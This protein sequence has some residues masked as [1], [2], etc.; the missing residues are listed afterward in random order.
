MAKQVRLADGSVETLPSQPLSF[1]VPPYS[2]HADRP[3][4]VTVADVGA[5]LTTQVSGR[6]H[7]LQLIRSSCF[8]HGLLK[9]SCSVA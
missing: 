9:P 1:H 8:S 2:Y 7:L 6:W 5:S 4:L 3:L